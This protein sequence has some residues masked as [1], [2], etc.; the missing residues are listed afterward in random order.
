MVAAAACV[1]AAASP[2]AAAVNQITFS[3]T[4]LG[5]AQTPFASDFN[6]TAPQRAFVQQWDHSAYS[7]TF[8]YDSATPLVG[9][10]FAA[11]LVAGSVGGNVNFFNGF[12]AY[13]TQEQAG[14]NPAWDVMTFTVSASETIGAFNY[15]RAAHFTIVDNEGGIFAGAGA[16]P[17]LIDPSILNQRN[18]NVLLRAPGGQQS[19]AA[20]NVGVATQA[21]LLPGP[22]VQPGAIPEPTAWA[23]LIMGFGGIGAMLRR[24]SAV[25]LA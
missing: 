14:N 24:R 2:A 19:F 20:Q 16:L 7:L 9:G 15:S 18:A 23:L 4:G 17:G 21:V 5:Q 1:L 25:G 3:G 22:P 8:Q 11:T 12:T 10:N 13:V 6:F